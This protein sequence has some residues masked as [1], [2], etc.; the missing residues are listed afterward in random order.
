MFTLSSSGAFMKV[1]PVNILKLNFPET[2][3]IKL[4]HNSMRGSE[5]YNLAKEAT[6]T[7]FVVLL[8]QFFILLTTRIFNRI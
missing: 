4:T 6:R 7:N 8:V 2:S 5:A 1:F 3:E